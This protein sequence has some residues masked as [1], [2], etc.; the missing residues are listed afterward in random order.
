MNL[1]KIALA[2]V[3]VMTLPGLAHAL[4][5]RTAPF[6]GILV[7]S[8][9]AGCVVTNGSDRESDRAVATLF[10]TNG[11]TL[12]TDGPIFVAPGDTVFG[13]FL[14]LSNSSPTWC[15]CELPNR[16]HTCA[17]MYI[18]GSIINVIRAE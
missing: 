2:L 10:D 13:N 16:Q 9:T 12:T 1:L 6:P 4:T 17:F 5:L 15:R 3:L 18:N 7:S 8:G 11:N 14:T